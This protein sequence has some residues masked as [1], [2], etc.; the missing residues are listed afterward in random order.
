MTLTAPNVINGAQTIMSLADADVKKINPE[1]FPSDFRVQPG[2]GRNAPTSSDF[3]VFTTRDG[4][5]GRPGTFPNPGA[6]SSD[7][8]ASCLFR[9]PN[10]S[11]YQR[12]NPQDEKDAQAVAFRR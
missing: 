1:T 7:E 8:N 4:P 2:G 5:G 12:F 11:M 10:I 3:L 6:K 9:P